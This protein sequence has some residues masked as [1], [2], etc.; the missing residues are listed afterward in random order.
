[1]AN[2]SFVWELGLIVENIYNI[3]DYYLCIKIIEVPTTT[4]KQIVCPGMDWV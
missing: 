1:M 4:D 3:T 2:T